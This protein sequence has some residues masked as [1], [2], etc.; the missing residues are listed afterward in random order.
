M[1]RKKKKTASVKLVAYKR[2]TNS[3]MRYIRDAQKTKVFDVEKLQ[4]AHAIVDYFNKDGSISK[5]KTK[6]AVQRNE[7]NRIILE[8]KEERTFT[9][10]KEDIKLERQRKRAEARKPIPEA[11]LQKAGSKAS[12]W[13]SFDVFK[14]NIFDGLI[15]TDAYYEIVLES[16]KESGTTSDDIIEVLRRI[17]NR[18]DLQTP[19][20]SKESQNLDDRF[21]FL[22]DI[23]PKIDKL[24]KDPN[25]DV[26]KLK[27]IIS[28][29]LKKY[30][31]SDIVKQNKQRLAHKVAQKRK[32]RK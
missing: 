10:S 3:A 12:A 19:S 5:R 31:E 14:D 30:N 20:D 27:Q 24:A 6:S 16:T 18:Y 25:R 15:D 17:R 9:K 28:D 7:F 1:P 4:K 23:M 2:V 13:A 32:K 29:A 22:E 26:T 11:Y 21:N 8:A